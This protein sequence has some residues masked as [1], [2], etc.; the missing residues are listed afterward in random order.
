MKK[1]F[2]TLVVV[3]LSLTATATPVKAKRRTALDVIQSEEN[4]AS[5]SNSVN[6]SVTLTAG[7]SVVVFGHN[8]NAGNGTRSCSD[9]D[10]NTYTEVK[11]HSSGIATFMCFAADVDGG[12]TTI[13]M[14]IDSGG[15]NFVTATMI[16]VEG[17]IEVTGT[18]VDATGSTGLDMDAGDVTSTEAP[19]LV[20]EGFAKRFGAGATKTGWTQHEVIY[21]GVE[22]VATLLSNPESSTGTVAC[23]ATESAG[24]GQEWSGVCGTFNEVGGGGGGSVVPVFNN[25]MIFRI[26]AGQ[27]ANALDN[28]E[29]GGGGGGSLIT[30]EDITYMGGFNIPTANSDFAHTLIVMTGRRVSGV[31]HL[32]ISQAHTGSF[33]GKDSFSEFIV[34]ASSGYHVTPASAN[35][36]TLYHNWGR[37]NSAAYDMYD[38]KYALSYLSSGDLVDLDGNGHTNW[39]LGAFFTEESSTCCLLMNW[40][41]QYAAYQWAWST[42]IT[43]LTTPGT[44]TPGAQETGLA[45]TTVAPIRF[46][47]G[48]WPYS[49]TE[50]CGPMRANTMVHLPDDTMGIAQQRSHTQQDIKNKGPSLWGGLA[51]PNL[52]TSVAFGSTRNGNAAYRTTDKV[53]P[54]AYLSHYSLDNHTNTAGFLTGGTPAWTMRRPPHSGGGFTNYSFDDYDCVDPGESSNSGEVDPDNY[55]GIGTATS[56]DGMGGSAYVDGTKKGFLT[57]AKIDVGHSWYRT[58]HCLDFYRDTSEARTIDLDMGDGLDDGG[59]TNDTNDDMIFIA[60]TFSAGPGAGGSNLHRV[61]FVNGGINQSLSVSLSTLDLTVNLATNG[62]GVVTSTAAQVKAAVEANSPANAEFTVQHTANSDGT[63]VVDAFGYT[64]LSGGPQLCPLHGVSSPTEVTGPTSTL[65]TQAILVY[66]IDTL[67]DSPIYSP[68]PTWIWLYDIEPNMAF[69]TDPAN[70]GEINGVYWDAVDRRLYVLAQRFVSGQPAPFVHVFQI[71]GT[72]P[73]PMQLFTRRLTREGRRITLSPTFLSL[74]A[75]GTIASLRRQK[76]R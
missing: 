22:A 47:V 15:T 53:A 24:D 23:E 73:T 55:S 52:S 30:E 14:T 18:P 37:S 63:G 60:K 56:N 57:V 33:A 7:N 50:I 44:G 67:P 2:L 76:R 34:P 13:T 70:V 58:R 8:V 40:G 39:P 26:G 59:I 25:P 3:L 35:T 36:A 64:K 5:F 10:G 74:V 6:L 75:I 31:P 61:R 43:D 19:N 9:N 45:T 38:G 49:G 66:D 48:D 72:P 12:S 32:L 71:A 51:Y 65:Y 54:D 28:E 42:S 16:E 17:I 20:V 68:E 27:R 46:C 29:E 62:S 1:W 4:Q 41:P 21:D 69:S 11:Y